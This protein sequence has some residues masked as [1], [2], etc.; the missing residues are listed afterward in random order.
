MDFHLIFLIVMQPPAKFTVFTK[1]FIYEKKFYFIS[2]GIR[3]T[4]F[5]RTENGEFIW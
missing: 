5:K 1:K 4:G 3:C 2:P